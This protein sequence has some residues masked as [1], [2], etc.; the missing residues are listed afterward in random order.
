MREEGGRIATMKPEIDPTTDFAFKRLF[1]DEQDDELRRDLLN[2][3]I[4]TP[5]LG[6][7][8]RELRLQSPM[9]ER[10]FAEDKQSIYDLRM[11]DQ[12]E[13]CYL[14]EMQRRGYWYFPKRA[15]Y[16]GALEYGRQLRSG[17]HHLTLQPVFV[18]CIMVKGWDD[19]A[20]WHQVFLFRERTTG[21]VFDDLE[22]HFVDLSLCGE[23]HKLNSMMCT[24][25]SLL[26]V[27][28]C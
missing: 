10:E 18:V 15:L 21:K 14:L 17:E 7:Q 6:T 2:A 23:A 20:P 16:Y 8:A 24:S 11:L 1:G 3:V 22:V 27:T 25:R 9:V 12:G 4:D 5:E 19:E 26:N 13:R 28:P